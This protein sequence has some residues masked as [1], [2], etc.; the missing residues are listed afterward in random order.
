ME[1]WVSTTIHIASSQVNNVAKVGLHMGGVEEDR[2]SW[3]N[4]CPHL[5]FFS[6]RHHQ[7]SVSLCDT[8]VMRGKMMDGGVKRE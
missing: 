7:I 8:Y 3:G 6:S 1:A 4:D 5:L 2:P